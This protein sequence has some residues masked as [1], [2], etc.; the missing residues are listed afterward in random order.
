MGK[1]G[2][3]GKGEG[4]GERETEGERQNEDKREGR[5]KKK[6]GESKHSTSKSAE[7]LLKASMVLFGTEKGT[8]GRRMEKRKGN[9]KIIIL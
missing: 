3:D 1:R 8:S 7:Q 6:T 2:R 5:R 4:D 9:W